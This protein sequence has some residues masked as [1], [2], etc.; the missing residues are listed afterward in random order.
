MILM[1][2]D[3]IQDLFCFTTQARDTV[4]SNEQS[5]DSNVENAANRRHANLS[6][7]IRT[8]PNYV[9]VVLARHLAFI[10]HFHL[11]RNFCM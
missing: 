4:E 9:F 7:Y 8:H 5:I 1:T 10:L 11:D 2:A 3:N 6:E